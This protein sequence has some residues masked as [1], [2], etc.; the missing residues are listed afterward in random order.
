MSQGLIIKPQGLVRQASGRWGDGVGVLWTPASIG[1]E[2]YWWRTDLADVTL[3]VGDVVSHWL[4]KI[5]GWDAA[6]ANNTFRP[7][8]KTGVDGIN[9]QPVIRGDG[10]DD[11]LKTAAFTSAI[12]QP[13]TVWCVATIASDNNLS[14]FLATGLETNRTI[15]S[16]RYVVDANEKCYQLNFGTVLNGALNSLDAAGTPVFHLMIT[17]YGL[18]D[19]PNVDNLWANG[20]LKVTGNAGTSALTGLTLFSIWSGTGFFSDSKIAEIGIVS[21]IISAA[22]QALLE[23]Y[24]QSRYG[25]AAW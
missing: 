23:A 22:D 11:Y 18:P 3:E 9:G 7:A 13:F 14:R 1:G 10:A 17:E 2:L 25:I 19:T 24:V 20:V 16:H 8:Y 6:Q 15:Y 4:D 12:T 5:V 21:G